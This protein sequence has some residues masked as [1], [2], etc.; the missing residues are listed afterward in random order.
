MIYYNLKQVTML[1]KYLKKNWFGLILVIV[2]IFGVVVRLRD[3][4]ILPIDA[5]PMRQS[6]TECVAYFL[7]TGKADFFHPKSCLMRPTSNTEGYFFL[8]MPF[9][10]SLIAISYKIF[11]FY[12]FAARLVNLLLYL[13]GG[14]ALYG[15]MSKWWNKITALFSVVAFS[16]IPGSIFFVGHAYHPDAI[17]VSFIFV[18]LFFGWK[19]RE[20]G[21]FI[22]LLL[23]GMFLGI[24]VASRP[25]G[26]ICLPLLGYFLYLRKSKI[27][28]YLII[29]FLS[30]GFYGWWRWWTNHL[31]IDISWEN[32]VLRDRQ[33]LLVWENIKA[34][35][36]KNVIG[37]TM[38]KIVSVLAGI[39]LI[40]SLIKKNKNTIPL[41][42]WALG[43]IVYWLI[44]PSGNLVHQ[45]YAD[46]YIPLF[47]ILAGIG[48]SFIFS[49]SK[50]V[51]LLLVPL[52]IY[53]GIRVAG[54]H[55]DDRGKVNELGIV[56]DIQIAIPEGKTLIYL[57]K[58]N[59]L[60]LS[61]SH[62]QGWMLGEWPVD[63]AVHPWSFVMMRQYKFDYLV[64]TKGV[65]DIILSEWNDIKAHYPM[66]ADLET[67]RV[68]Q[69]KE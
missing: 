65:A 43:I 39:G 7:A 28:D 22:S 10:E 6:D 49:K 64:E 67:I 36:W 2:L 32:W 26:L 63:V 57:T 38:G 53:N 60:P 4:N 13:V 66:V 11:G 18:S 50:I 27:R 41:V 56:R 1:K 42:L 24:S 9:Y 33:Q 16:F 31:G 17:A 12:P 8:E 25:F 61:L 46:V 52:V 21:K 30:L 45:Y 20:K 19:Y 35:V 15:F 44:V 69:Y 29:L 47:A 14:L 3:F 37:E 59:S 54:Y 62:R 68:Y 5:H 48:L 23:A 55:F 40:I 51:A 58:A 34:L